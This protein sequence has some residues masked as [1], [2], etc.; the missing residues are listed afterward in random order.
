MER[1]HRPRGR[2][3]RSEVSMAIAAPPFAGFSPAEIH[4]LAALA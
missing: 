2:A 1:P 4:F 3:P